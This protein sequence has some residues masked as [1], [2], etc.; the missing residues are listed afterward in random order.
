M[1]TLSKLIVALDIA[2]E[3]AALNLVDRLSGTVDVFKIG[4]QLFTAGG[5]AIIKQVQAKG[6]KVFLDLKLHDIPNTVAKAV[7]AAQKHGVYAMTVHL[8]GGLE[9]L[10]KAAA[11][12]PRPQLW[13]VTVLTSLNDDNLKRVGVKFTVK[14][15]VQ[16]LAKLAKEA[17]LDGII[18][19]PQ[20][21][22]ITRPLVGDTFTIVTP[23]VRAKTADDDQKRT[24]SA[25]EAVKLGA[26]FIV[27]G[28]PV[29]QA[30]DP[31]EAAL[32]MLKEI[33]E[34]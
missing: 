25:S 21:I 1:L 5:P 23:G 17:G 20:E 9:M 6:G 22:T 4:L 2:D 24:L 33:G 10:Q 27:V 30:N 7:E 28:R 11:V 3:P 26:D 19:S 31:R 8:A 14:E 13:G 12:K 16:N 34:R 18:C 32:N 15:Q 29:I